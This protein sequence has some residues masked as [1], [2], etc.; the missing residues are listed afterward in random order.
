MNVKELEKQTEATR[1]RLFWLTQHVAHRYVFAGLDPGNAG[2]EAIEVV[3]HFRAHQD[4]LMT[5]DMAAFKRW[6]DGFVP[7]QHVEKI[8][9]ALYQ[10]TSSLFATKVTSGKANEGRLNKFSSSFVASFI[11]SAKAVVANQ[12]KQHAESLRR[13]Q[14]ERAEAKALAEALVEVE[15]M[16]PKH[17]K[18]QK[19]KPL[20]SNRT[21]QNLKAK[22]LQLTTEFLNTFRL[23][24]RTKH[25]TKQCARTKQYC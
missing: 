13:E 23:E 10:V 3:E 2:V 8:D 1:E 21:M 12:V 4:C 22:H 20:T 25:R 18:E 19:S 14:D 17:Q 15:A 7:Q 24:H 5:M 9:P 6:G 16:M 11:S